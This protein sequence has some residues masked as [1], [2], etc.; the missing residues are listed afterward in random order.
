[1]LPWE[2]GWP[3]PSGRIPEGRGEETEVRVFIP[4]LAPSL[5]GCCLLSGPSR[6]QGL[7]PNAGTCSLR[8]ITH[9]GTTAPHGSPYTLSPSLE[10]IPLLNLPEV[11]QSTLSLSFQDPDSPPDITYLL[12][13]SCLP[14]TWTIRTLYSVFYP[15]IWLSACRVAP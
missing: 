8:S 2:A 6:T 14:P 10:V 13:V 9:S 1:M 15:N 11:T 12:F 3:V 7:S 4:G 5:Q